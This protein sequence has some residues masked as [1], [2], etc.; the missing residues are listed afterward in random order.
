IL[1]DLRGSITAV[2]PFELRKRVM[3]Q[4]AWSAGQSIF[5]F[6][7]HSAQDIRTRQDIIDSYRELAHLI[8]H[9]EEEVHARG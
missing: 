7:V 2:T 1:S 5:S 8:L 9:R 3:L 4:G 6:D